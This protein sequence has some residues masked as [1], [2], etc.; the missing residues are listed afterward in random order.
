MQAV[1]GNAHGASCDRGTTDAVAQILRAAGLTVAI[2][3]PYAGGAIV[4]RHGRPALGVQAL[5]L[6]FDRTLYLDP[7]LGHPGPHVGH[8]RRLVQ[9]IAETLAASEALPIAA[10]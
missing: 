2:N 7:A 3:Q 9:S 6:E 5:Q 4:R 8:I 10:E 1:L